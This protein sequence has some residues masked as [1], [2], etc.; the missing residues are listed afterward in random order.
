MSGAGKGFGDSPRLSGPTTP[1]R[2]QSG[3]GG[4]IIFLSGNECFRSLANRDQ[5]VDMILRPDYGM[6]LVMV[7]FPSGE[8]IDSS[9]FS[10]LR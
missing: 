10:S 9:P 1:E 8:I 6:L 5:A 4:S 2:M 3:S 7:T